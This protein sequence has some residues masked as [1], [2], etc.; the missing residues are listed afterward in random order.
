VQTRSLSERKI[1][2]SDSRWLAYATAGAATALG[3]VAATEEAIGSIH[4]SGP[5]DQFFSDNSDFFELDQAGDS[6]NLFHAGGEKLGAAAFLVSGLDAASVAGF[7]FGKSYQYVSKLASGVSLNGLG[8]WVAG[9][10]TMAFGMGYIYSQ[11]LEPGTGFVGFRFDGGNGGLQ[12]G[13]A[14]ITM[15]GSPGNTF[16]LVD[17][18]WADF[19]DSIEAGQVPESGSLALLALGGAGLAAW[20]KRR[21]KVIAA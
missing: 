15:D 1:S 7:A 18:A 12:Y 4:Y 6:I 14:R 10:G 3:F 5:I 16:T 21:S 9:G 13:W 17:F 19:G 11:W 8:A 20:R 2:I